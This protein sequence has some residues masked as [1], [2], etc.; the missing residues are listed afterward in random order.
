LF[1]AVKALIGQRSRQRNGATSSS[2]TSRFP[3][4]LTRQAV[5]FLD[6][7]CRENPFGEQ[8]HWIG[9]FPEKLEMTSHPGWQRHTILPETEFRALMG[10]ARVVLSFSNY[11]GFGRPPVEAAL[12]GGCPVFSDIP[13]SREVM[14]DCGYSFDNASYES[15]AAALGK[16]LTVRPEQLQVWADKLAARHNWNIVADRV[17]SALSVASEL[18]HS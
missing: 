9:S 17:V 3:H 16:A 1:A 6:R 18:P 4:K 15:F 13:A 7:W 11:E 2:P 10:R 14:G 12:A 8:I 5:E